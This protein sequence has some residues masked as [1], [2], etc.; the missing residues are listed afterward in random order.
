VNTLYFSPEDIKEAVEIL[1]EFNEEVEV[2]AGG[3][4]ILVQYYERLDDVNYW[5]DLKEINSLKEIDLCKDKIEIGAGVTHSQLEKSENI[6]KYFS[7]LSE[8]AANVGSPQIRNRGTIGGNVVNASP[9]GDLL[10]GLLAYEAEFKI[11]SADEE[12]IVPAKDFFVGPGKSILKPNQLLTKIII[13]KAEENTYGNWTK[14][15]M[16]KAVAISTISLALVVKF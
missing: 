4:D 2:L 12:V 10:P 8:A 7:I 5:L 1:D 14:I 11:D 9:A 6:N 13:S 15:G 3:T 16:R